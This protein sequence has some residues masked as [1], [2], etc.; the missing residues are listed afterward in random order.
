MASGRRRGSPCKAPEL[1]LPSAARCPA[2]RNGAMKG[3][4]RHASPDVAGAH[5]L[6]PGPARAQGSARRRGRWPTGWVGISTRGRSGGGEQARC[7]ER[8]GQRR[9]APPAGGW[10]ATLRLAKT[11]SHAV[12]PDAW[13]GR[14]RHDSVAD[15]GPHGW[16]GHTPAW[17]WKRRSPGPS[18]NA[19]AYASRPERRRLL[20]ETGAQNGYDED[21]AHRNG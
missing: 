14:I 10:R 5:V 12:A 7:P 1:L 8:R 13:A 15:G 16:R 3:R 9:T 4:T 2:P 19:R 18:C 20:V 6:P 11:G 17:S 21:A